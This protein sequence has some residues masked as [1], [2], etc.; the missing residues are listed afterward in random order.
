MHTYSSAC[1]VCVCVEMRAMLV[2]NSCARVYGCVCARVCVC[3]STH[4]CDA[5]E[6]LMR[7]TVV[8]LPQSGLYAD[9]S[10]SRL[11]R[12]PGTCGVVM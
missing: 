11:V 1:C 4:M 5:D 8:S 3:L 6:G 12:K 7:T 10:S 9:D 2:S